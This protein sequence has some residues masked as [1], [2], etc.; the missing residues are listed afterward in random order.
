VEI[1][2]NQ[3]EMD[4]TNLAEGHRGNWKSVG[5]VA[6]SIN[7]NHKQIGKLSEMVNLR[8]LAILRL[9]EIVFENQ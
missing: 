4:T 3:Q 5:E 2:D 8:L 9:L 7:S 6:P 1:F